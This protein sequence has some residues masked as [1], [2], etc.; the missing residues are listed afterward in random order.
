MEGVAAPALCAVCE[1]RAQEQPEPLA[2]SNP[3]LNWQLAEPVS[4]LAN[5]FPLCLLLVRQAAGL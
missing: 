2:L 5:L 1:P 4:L 3:P